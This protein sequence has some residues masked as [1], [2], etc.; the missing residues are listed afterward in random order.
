M[1]GSL[2]AFGYASKDAEEELRGVMLVNSHALIID[3]RLTPWCGWSE[4]WQRQTLSARWS[5]RYIWRGDW[6]GNVNHTTRSKPILLANEQEGIPW[7]VRGL[8]KGF[9]LILLCGCADPS[10][11]H[12]SVIYTKV[13]TALGDRFPLFTLGQRVM[14]PDGPGMINPHIPLYIHQARNRYA[15]LLDLITPR[16]YYDPSQLKPYD[17]LQHALLSEKEISYA[18]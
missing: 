18:S 5:K 9:T 7:L 16:R 2:A 8:E 10:T 11:C 13:L 4:V 6:L 14:T 12:R 1:L 3:T 17:V 15:V